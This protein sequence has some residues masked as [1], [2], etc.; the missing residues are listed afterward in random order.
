M[1]EITSN[2]YASTEYPGVNVGF[3]VVPEGAIAVDAPTLPQDA[4]AWRQRVEQVAGGPILYVVL[5]DTH[6]DRLL[7]AGLLGAPIV[8]A[9][10][11]YERASVYTDGFWRG[12]IDGWVRRHPE[13]ASDLAGARVVL[14]EIMFT[15][16]VTL[17]KGGRDVTVESVVGAASGSARLYLREEGVIFLGDTLVAETHPFLAA[18][19]DTRA[20]LNTLRS[21]RRPRNSKIIIVPGR[22]P[23]CDCS[24]AGPL[25]EYITLAR[26]R[27]RSL[28]IAGRP[29]VD[30]ASLV[31]ELISLYPVP[32]DGRDYVHRRVR[33]GLDRLYEEL[34]PE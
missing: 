13:A 16:R 21:L 29:R 19:P 27:V 10:A 23:L 3:I 26:R 1:K 30:T 5:T 8:A 7:S 11:A 12:V 31:A 4:R 14:P 6:P 2:I 9:R 22:G 20:W 18:A 24:A 15:S 33:A 34:R 25:G 17:R 32:D 28:H